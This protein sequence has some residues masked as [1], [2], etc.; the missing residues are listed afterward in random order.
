MAGGREYSNHQRKIINRYYEHQ[1]T[2]IT[3]RLGEIVSEMALAMGDEKKLAR[4]WKRAD[5]ALAKSGL[6]AS[7]AARI[8]EKRDVEG[9]AKAVARLS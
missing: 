9:L 7:E 8:V 5:Q 4:L 3:H 6:S 2:I 1:D